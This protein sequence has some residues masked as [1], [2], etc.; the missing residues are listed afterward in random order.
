[1]TP[2]PTSRGTFTVTC[3]CGTTAEADTR[4]ELASWWADHRAVHAAEREAS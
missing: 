3:P 1:V 4:N 2:S